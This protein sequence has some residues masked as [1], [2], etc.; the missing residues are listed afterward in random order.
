MIYDPLPYGKTCSKCKQ[1]KPIHRFHHDRHQASGFKPRCKM[2]C[3]RP[4]RE[5]EREQGRRFRETSPDKYKAAQ[6]R[7]RENHRDELRERSRLQWVN[8]KPKRQASNR[9]HHQTHKELMA[10]IQRRWRANHREVHRASVRQRRLEKPREIYALNQRYRARKQKAQGKFDG[11][12]LRWQFD[13]QH[14]KCFWCSEPIEFDTCHADH[15]IPLSRG[16]TNWISN[17]VC[18][19]PFC[20]ASKHDKLPFDEWQPSNPLGR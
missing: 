16:G 6:Q 9:K 14:G 20:N 19:C 4:S 17:V 5:Y 15:I 12:Q 8:N 18:S 13:R 7:Y 2:C 11:K 3:E 10:D 1:W